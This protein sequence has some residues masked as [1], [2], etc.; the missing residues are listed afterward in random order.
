M[1]ECELEHTRKAY[2]QTLVE[3]GLEYPDIVVVDADLSSSTQT[4]MFQKEYPE[5]FFNVGCAEQN[6]MGLSAGLALGGKTVFTSGFAMFGVGRGWEQIRN[7]IG[8]G[9]LNVNIVMTHA[10]LTVGKD[11][12][13]HQIFEDLALMRS[14][15]GMRVMVPA[16]APETRAMVRLCNQIPGP[17]YIRLTREKSPTIFKGYEGCDPTV[18]TV[19]CDGSDLTI[20]ACG[21]LLQEAVIAHKI[22]KDEG[23]SSRLINMHT[24][25]PLH[26]DTVIK[27]ARQTGALVT[28]EE[29]SI[30]GGLGGAVAECLCS[31]SPAPLMR[32][33]IEDRFGKS[34]DT[35]EL[36]PLY[37]L[38]SKTIVERA[39]RALDMKK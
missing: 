6:L 25:K 22:L 17:T 7:T 1:M 19:M 37:N 18:P 4:S 16:D 32:V 27:A 26:E 21:Y 31:N 30:I 20:L 33:G 39:K 14:I 10:G 13:S 3:L 5:R 29:H 2:G 38:T 23:I 15:P 12:S 34:G 28:V 11:G 36:L 35:P 9:S 8:Y 24:I